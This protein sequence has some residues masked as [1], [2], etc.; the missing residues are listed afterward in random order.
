[1][2]ILLIPGVSASS[3]IGAGSCCP[4]DNCGCAAK[5]RYESVILYSF[6]YQFQE[7]KTKQLIKIL[8]DEFDLSPIHSSGMD[9]WIVC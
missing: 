4:S 3:E 7:M 9:G 6:F 1:M 8:E 5:Q 2:S